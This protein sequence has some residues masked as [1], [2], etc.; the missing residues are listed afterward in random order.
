MPLVLQAFIDD[1]SDPND[2]PF[3]LAGFIST[4][5]RW[6]A[7][8]RDWEKA[9]PKWGRISKNGTYHFKMSEMASFGE[10]EKV[11]GLYRIIE[12][13]VQ[14]A[15]SC[16]FIKEDLKLA[17]ARL[18]IP[19][20]WIDW[21]WI[22]NYYLFAYRALMDMF[23]NNRAEYMAAIL[24][25]SEKIDFYFDAQSE[26]R[27]IKNQWTEYLERR[28]QG[29]KGLYG[30]EPI[31]RHDHELLPLQA[32]DFW[33]WWVRKWTSEKSWEAKLADLEFGDW[34][35]DPYRVPRA[36]IVF[37]EDALAQTL[38]ELI[39][40]QEPDVVLID[41][42]NF[43]LTGRWTLAGEDFKLEPT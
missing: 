34:K 26:S 4:S 22:D 31:F 24:P 8:S 9:L 13:H 18:C 43:T 37:D 35:A 7:F 2:G 20:R 41:L 17:K 16:A 21:G 39:R 14:L 10:M 28:P 27:T 3:V 32:A 25:L 11:A 23:H 29:T 5:E 1:S 6:D 40:E 15:V 19:G 38:T 30:K 36:H 42:K 33:A 12:D